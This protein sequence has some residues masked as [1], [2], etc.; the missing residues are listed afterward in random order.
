MVLIERSKISEAR[1]T[2]LESSIDG[3]L[4]ANGFSRRGK[5]HVYIRSKDGVKQKIDLSMQLSPSYGNGAFAHVIPYYS[6]LFKDVEKVFKEMVQGMFEYSIVVASKDSFTI[7]RQIQLGYKAEYEYWFIKS[8]TN[9][10]DLGA[11]IRTFIEDHTLPF[12]NDYMSV[13]DLI[14]GYEHQDKRVSMDDL[15]YVQIASAYVVV[16]DYENGMAVLEKRFGNK[17]N[18]ERYKIAFD[19]IS[20]KL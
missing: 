9:I 7:H 12:L 4:F 3:F 10:L 17:G 6:I 19:Y 5:S 20:R 8:D 16:G 13:E 2:L 15:H 18:R 11:K 14:S 1:I